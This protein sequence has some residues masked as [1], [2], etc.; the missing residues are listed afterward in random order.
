MG[1]D[2]Q[3]KTLTSS[4]NLEI[5]WKGDSKGVGVTSNDGVSFT[6][7]ADEATVH[8]TEGVKMTRT[9]KPLICHICGKNHYTNRYPDREDR[10]QGKRQLK[11]RIPQE[12]KP[13][14]KNHQ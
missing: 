9:S 2:E 6:T 7:E 12:W 1:R 13:P 8:A 3:P 5:K 11:R 4:Y 14:P 10:T